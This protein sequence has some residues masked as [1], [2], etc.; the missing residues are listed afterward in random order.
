MKK[1]IITG[2]ICFTDLMEAAKAGNK[3]FSRAAN[4]KVYLS[5][6]AW[7]KDEDDKFGNNISFQL[8]KPKDS[9]E[10]QPYFGNAKFYNSEKPKETPKQDEEENPFSDQLPF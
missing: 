10:K 5:F 7:E 6:V 4:G 9:E 3:A 8:S 1:P 2:S